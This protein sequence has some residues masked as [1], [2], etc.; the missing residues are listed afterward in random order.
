MPAVVRLSKKELIDLIENTEATGCDVACLRGLLAE[1]EE[2]EE[3]RK[4]ERRGVPLGARPEEMT[5]EDY[6]AEK[7]AETEIEHGTD[8]ECMMCHQKFDHL[9]CGTCEVCF[10]EWM[11]STKPPARVKKVLY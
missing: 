4:P 6:L 3:L 8:L 2:E 11:L 1:V 5:I 9:L 7:R 10:R